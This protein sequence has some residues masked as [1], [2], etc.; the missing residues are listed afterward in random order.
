MCRLLARNITVSRQTVQTRTIAILPFRK[1]SCQ[2]MAPAPDAC[3]SYP[4]ID[5]PLSVFAVS[6]SELVPDGIAE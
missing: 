5:S 3:A 6:F 2:V 1:A 4:E